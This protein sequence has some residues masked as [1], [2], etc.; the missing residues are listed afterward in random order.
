MRTIR[1][2][3]VLAALIGSAALLAPR[4][5]QAQTITACYAS[6]SGSMYRVG[7]TGT[8]TD[9]T[10]QQ[11]K[12]ETWNVTGPQGP[13]GDAGTNG[14]NGTNG[15][16]GFERIAKTYSMNANSMM[17][18]YLACPNGKAALGAGYL[19]SQNVSVSNSWP[20]SFKEQ[21]TME[22]HSGSLGLDQKP[23]SLQVWVTCATVN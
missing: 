7:V 19:G 12:K 6:K 17:V 23:N 2:L 5:A 3:S 15:V 8:P 9:C 11:H 4:N 21:W 18:I 22:A 16:S 1:S 13:K 20:G 14:T 10:N